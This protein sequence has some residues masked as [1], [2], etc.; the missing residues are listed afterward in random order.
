MEA[1]DYSPS[2]SSLGLPKNSSN[3]FINRH[4]LK[5]IILIFIIVLT[6]T[7]K[8]DC[9][10][11]VLQLKADN[12]RYNLTP[13]LTRI[14]H[15]GINKEKNSP[16]SIQPRKRTPSQQSSVLWF[17]VSLLNALPP[18]DN[19]HTN[20]LWCLDSGTNQ[21]SKM[22][23]YHLIA[24]EGTKKLVEINTDSFKINPLREER[25]HLLFHLPDTPEN[26]SI[27]YLSVETPLTLLMAP[28]LLTGVAFLKKNRK[29]MIWHGIIYGIFFSMML[30]NGFLFFSLRDKNY[31]WYLLWVAGSMG[32]CLHMDGIIAEYFLKK[33][34]P[35]ALAN[36]SHVMINL[37]MFFYLQF[38]RNF[39]ATASRVPRFDLIIRFFLLV[40]VILL[41]LIPFTS[42]AVMEK[43]VSAHTG[44]LL[45]FVLFTGIYCWWKGFRAARFFVFASTAFI[46]GATNHI[47]VFSGILPFIGILF[48][49]LQIGSAIEA[50]LLSFALADKVKL[51][52]TER[53]T[54]M[55]AL[56]ES[57]I[58]NRAQSLFLANMSH[59]L[60][61]PL[62][63]ILG[64]SQLMER[65][66]TSPGES[67]REK[68]R[69]IINSAEHLLSMIN[70]VLDMSK[71]ESDHIKLNKKS[72]DPGS[73]II[74]I[75]DM[76]RIR[77]EK[78]HLSLDCTISP[79]VPG[80]IETDER[81]L[82]QILINLLS[83]AVKFTEK[84]GVSLR[85]SAKDEEIS[86][87][88]FEITDTGR[89]ICKEDLE[90]IFNPFWQSENLENNINGT[91]L[92][93]SI[94]RKFVQLL[95]GSLSVKSELGQGSSFSFSISFDP[96]S[97]EDVEN[98][99]TSDTEQ[100]YIL[101]GP[102]GAE[103]YDDSA[104]GN[105]SKLPHALLHELKQAV[106][107][108][109]VTSIRALIENIRQ[110]DTRLAD[111]IHKLA[112]TYRYDLLLESISSAS[113]KH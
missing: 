109:N 17:S 40:C 60:R 18:S 11:K 66:E 85:V 4:W 105:L 41:F 97:T 68:L 92:G 104:M 73:V 79:E 30:Y 103:D 58:T 62:N 112:K 82:R 108:L 25:N 45:N 77:A 23:L 6:G 100:I 65:D 48:N 54:T 7:F 29:Q 89:G 39:L 32:Y 5:S 83:N 36:L 91:G 86:H 33:T 24:S 110:S 57:E 87:L 69:I 31:M 21:M 34:D 113:P 59:E 10:E 49:G 9:S 42:H 102:M 55:K 12:D 99:N 107:E 46:I 2:V 75:V 13:Y 101:S 90:K 27:L 47:L 20:N 71:I 88:F 76:I 96:P 14:N 67:H 22:K 15:P 98:T 106:I 80:F 51:L 28:E 56:K 111:A 43:L 95:N 72:F 8:A 16:T 52:R 70:Q 1:K 78:K 37:A 93:L 94:S 64:F 44:L 81:L 35:L 26:H 50:I 61:T 74:N 19:T 3:V 84:G 63:A 53:E 38:T